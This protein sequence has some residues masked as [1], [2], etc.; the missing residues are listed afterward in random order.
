MATEIKIKSTRGRKPLPAGE[1]KVRVITFV[2][3]KDL[4]KFKEIAKQFN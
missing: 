3:A 4:K 1:K 2:K